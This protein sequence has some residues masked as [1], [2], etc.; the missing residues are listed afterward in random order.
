MNALS[1]M[2]IACPCA[3]GLAT[4]IAVS[5]ATSEAAKHGALVKNAESLERIGTTNMV[6]FDKTGTLTSGTISVVEIIDF[7]GKGET[8][9]LSLAGSVEL[10]S[11]HPIAKAIVEHCK[12][13][14]IEVGNNNFQTWKYVRGMG[15]VGNTKEGQAIIAG[16]MQLIAQSG[17]SLDQDIQS[18]IRAL[19]Q[20]G[21]S[22]LLVA[23]DTNLEGMIVLR[24]SI[25]PDAAESVQLLNKMGIE[26][27]MVT[28]DNELVARNVAQQV[29]IKLENVFYQVSPEGKADLIRT[30]LTNK[31]VAMVGDGVNDVVGL[32]AAD[33]SIAMGGGTDIA[34]EAADIT[35]TREDL[36]TIPNLILLS[37]KS[38]S[39]IKQNL[40]LSFVYNIVA[41][42]M[43]A[44]GLLNPMIAAAAM[45]ASSLCV[46]TNSLRLKN[47]KLLPLSERNVDKRDETVVN[48]P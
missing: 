46:V 17:I 48:I 9:V 31:S 15:V 39:N 18:K 41:M 35:M 44:Y 7:S 38:I 22:Y 40:F 8:N 12:A 28:G 27:A 34:T 5:L 42:P 45:S 36:R 11:P 21:S 1:V 23:K 24:D 37:R 25:R 20:E 6:V 32:S 14:N 30:K 4:P 13:N 43:A 16:N 47:V 29:G 2:V 19:S 26:V 33:T 3:L 10:K